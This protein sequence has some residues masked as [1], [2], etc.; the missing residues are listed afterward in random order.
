MS[1]FDYSD[2]LA[3]YENPLLLK[4]G[5]QKVVFLAN[6]P[7]HGKVALKIGTY[8]Y[9]QTLVRMQ[10]EVDVLSGIQ[11][12]YYPKCFEFKELPNNRFVILEE[13]VESMP[14][15]S[16]LDKYTNPLITLGLIKSLVTGIEILWDKRIV[17]RDVKPDNLLIRPDGSLKI[18]DLGIARLLDQESITRTLAPMGPC[19]PVYASPEQLSNR[20][21]II[22][23][24]T[25]QFSIGIVL[26]QLLAGG[27]H[28]FD[29]TVV[30]S[31]SSIVENIVNGKWARGLLASQELERLRP[32]VVKLLGPEPYQRY[33]IPEKLLGDLDKV[34][35]ASK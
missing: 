28:P 15:S 11:S 5:G 12:D 35:E 29:P 2:I 26:L 22:D 32:V 17:H 27:L 1:S 8:V 24:R 3:D 13:Y 16:L 9:P 7:D 10:R 18:I 25:D 31:G 34:M 21:K 20:K 33:R 14:L 30:G 19:T 6:H 4:Q 23:V